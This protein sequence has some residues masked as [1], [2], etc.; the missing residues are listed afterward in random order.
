[1][2]E[3]YIVYNDFTK[4]GV[5]LDII[6]KD[7]SDYLIIK[8]DYGII[9]IEP[10]DNTFGIFDTRRDFIKAF[11]NLIYDKP[12]RLGNINNIEV[13]HYWNDSES[14]HKYI[15]HSVLM[16]KDRKLRIHDIN[17][18]SNDIFEKI[19]EFLHKYVK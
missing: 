1:M 19:E 10:I 15:S 13:T 12:K 8:N 14:G 16:F 3:K 11:Y 4:R 7:S 6:L 2:K 5:I 9:I 17:N 18:P